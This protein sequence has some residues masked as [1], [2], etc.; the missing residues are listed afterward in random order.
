IDTPAR[1]VVRV[2]TRDGRIESYS[3][4]IDGLEGT[5]NWRPS[6]NWIATVQR[7]SEEDAD[8]VF[9]ERNGL[10][11]GGFKLR[12]PGKMIRE[13]IWNSDSSVLAV[14]LEDR[15]QLWTVSN[16]NWTLKQEI[17][18]IRENEA[19]TLAAK[20]HNEKPLILFIHTDGI[21]F[22]VCRSFRRR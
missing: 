6:G 18:M 19:E 8:V 14:L 3:E 16:Y 22:R 2:Y 5:L 12:K 20:W 1:R 11:H 21:S 4:P 15:I 10:R 17:V 7:F 9:L 13:L